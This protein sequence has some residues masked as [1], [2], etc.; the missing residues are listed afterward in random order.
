MRMSYCMFLALSFS[1]LAPALNEPANAGLVDSNSV[2]IRAVTGLDYSTDGPMVVLLD[3]GQLVRIHGTE[4]VPLQDV[5]PVP[6]AEVLVFEAKPMN[7]CYVEYLGPAYL[8]TQ[9]AFFITNLIAQRIGRMSA[10]C[11]GRAPSRQRSRR[12]A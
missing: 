3:S 4:V 2:G 6:A 5:L 11:P 7:V 9:G 12:G 10:H 8:I 1:V